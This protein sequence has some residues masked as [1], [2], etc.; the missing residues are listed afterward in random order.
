LSKSARY[1]QRLQDNCENYKSAESIQFL[2][3]RG[4]DSQLYTPKP[5]YIVPASRWAFLQFV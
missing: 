3:L 4:L 5:L 2:C 1:R